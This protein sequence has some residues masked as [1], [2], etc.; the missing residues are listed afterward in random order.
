MRENQKEMLE[1]IVSGYTYEHQREIFVEECAEAIK[2]VQKVKR[3]AELSMGA[4]NKAVDELAGEVA[5]VLITAEQMQ[6]YLGEDKIDKAID[7]KLK[8][9]LQRMR[10]G[11]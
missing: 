10:D 7:R 8:R 3:A 1:M 5:D 4:F 6:L 2:A 11:L 9:Q